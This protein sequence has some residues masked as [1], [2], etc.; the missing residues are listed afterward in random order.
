MQKELEQYKTWLLANSRSKNTIRSYLHYVEVFLSTIGY[1]DNYIF[2]EEKLN[3]YFAE[4]KTKTIEQATFNFILSAV[5]SFLVFKGLNIRTPYRKAPTNKEVQFIDEKIFHNV[6]IPFVDQNFNDALRVKTALYCLFYTGLRIKEL[7]SLHRKDFNFDRNLLIANATK[8]N[9]ERPIAILDKLKKYLVIYFQSEAEE[10]NCFNL[11]TSRV[12]VMFQVL[13]VNLPELKIHPHKFRAS[14]ACYCYGVL[15]LD[16]LTIQKLLG[17][18]SIITT[19]R[20]V[21][22]LLTNEM[23]NMMLQKEKEH[24]QKKGG[25]HV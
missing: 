2:T 17:H 13:R 4:L 1:F 6:I 21:K 5:K 15:K 24:T 3:N 23:V 19:M 14:F 16:I 10:E 20:Y 22:P 25:N 12:D 8:Q 7:I 11:S 18:Q 9:W